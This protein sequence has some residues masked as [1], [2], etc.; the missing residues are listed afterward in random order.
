MRCKSFSVCQLRSHMN[1]NQNWVKLLQPKISCCSQKC[2]KS[3]WL[4]QEKGG[5]N[6]M[7]PALNYHY[8][9]K[10]QDASTPAA[11]WPSPTPWVLRTCSTKMPSSQSYKRRCVACQHSLDNQTLPMQARAGEENF[12]HILRN[13]DCVTCK[14]QEEER[15]GHR[16]NLCTAHE[17]LKLYFCSTEVEIL[18][19]IILLCNDI[20]V[21]EKTWKNN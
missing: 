15:E 16:G 14:H 21:L 19:T 8:T 10:A 4:D 9:T 20:P 6:P 3:Q 2:V 13:P 11:G 17:L 5:P 1:R 18:F 7:L 12:I